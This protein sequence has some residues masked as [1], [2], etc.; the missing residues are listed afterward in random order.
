M[1]GRYGEILLEATGKDGNEGF[2]H[3]A[4][5]IVENEAN[6]N[7]TWFVSTLGD[8]LYDKDVYYKII[9]FISDRSKVLVNATAK[10]FHRS[11]HAYCLQHLQANFFKASYHL[12]NTLK[13]EY[14]TLIVKVAYVCTSAKYEDVV[15]A[16]SLA[17]ILVQTWLF[18]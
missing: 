16:L 3:L 8:A 15:Q 10:V 5:A 18:Q 1:L 6:K 4:F 9:M 12:G 7:W 17:S 2:F 14:W 11:P 13:D